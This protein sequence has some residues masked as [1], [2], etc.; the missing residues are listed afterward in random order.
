MP[1]DG[2]ESEELAAR[3]TVPM[4]VTFGR[5]TSTLD[6]VHELAREGAPAGALVL[7]DEQMAG[8][9]RH[10]RHWYSPPGKGVW[11]GYLLRTGS[12]PE[13]G[14]MSVRVGLAT[15][16]ALAE[17]G[18]DPRLKWPNDVLLADRKVA[19]ILC[20]TRRQGGVGWIGLGIGVNVHGPMPGALSPNAVALDE[21]CA[22]VT[23][24]AVLERLVP[25]LA[26]LSDAPTLTED[27]R[28]SY[29]RRD[30]LAGRHLAEPVAG[31]AKGV[32]A[33]GALLVEAVDGVR[34]VVGGSIDVCEE[35]HDAAGD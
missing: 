20:E 7:A 12:A 11:L 4:C 10:G 34:Q 22:G 21:V 32:A 26:R 17:L 30:W 3:L 15:A 27:E 14:V 5:V 29:G 18:A 33:S 16:T 31:V 28:A 9:G 23:R 6:I 35:R 19:G 25:R 13:G 24:V 2:I 8:R 1:Y